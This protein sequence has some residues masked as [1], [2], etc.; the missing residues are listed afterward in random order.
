MGFR[1]LGQKQTLEHVRVMSALPPKADIGTQ[2]V[3]VRHETCASAQ[4]SAGRN[5]P[6][7]C[8]ITRFKVALLIARTRASLVGGHAG[9]NP[10]DLFYASLLV[11]GNNDFIAPHA[12]LGGWSSHKLTHI[13][14]P[15]R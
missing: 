10:G 5:A 8:L 7:D 1:D 2:S 6:I 13:R 11:L 12:D 15:R 3:N 4:P 14:A 9:P